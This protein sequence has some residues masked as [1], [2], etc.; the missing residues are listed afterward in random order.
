MGVGRPL[1]LNAK[2]LDHTLTMCLVLLPYV[3]DSAGG[4]D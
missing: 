2:Q 4:P 1:F 3:L